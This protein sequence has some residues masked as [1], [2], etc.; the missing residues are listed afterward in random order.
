MPDILDNIITPRTQRT[1]DERTE[2]IEAAQRLNPD[3]DHDDIEDTGT[4]MS[5]G[6]YNA[7]RRRLNNEQQIR[8]LE[9]TERSRY[10]LVVAQRAAAR[11]FVHRFA[12]TAGNGDPVA[13]LRLIARLV[14]QLEAEM[15]AS[16]AAEEGVF[17]RNVRALSLPGGRVD[18]P[19]WEIYMRGRGGAFNAN[20]EV[21]EGTWGGLGLGV[22]PYLRYNYPRTRGGESF[23]VES[24]DP[25][26]GGPEYWIQYDPNRVLAQGLL[27]GIQTQ[28][29]AAARTY[30]N[31]Q[32]ERGTA[33]GMELL[34][35]VVDRIP[36]IS[37]QQQQ[38]DSSNRNAPDGS[39]T[40]R[41][42]STVTVPRDR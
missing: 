34:G 13:G 28:L 23:S 22:L 36:G 33:I 11:R 8:A 7:N 3:L 25:V 37:L 40:P 41:G 2:N 26:F 42:R 30:I 29:Q 17:A 4:P 18:W 21:Q 38:Q 31:E 20:A 14:P 15:A 5:Q 19:E 12:T 32:R 10:S 27:P 9:R 24:E 6:T 1:I 39:S 35:Q 16:Y